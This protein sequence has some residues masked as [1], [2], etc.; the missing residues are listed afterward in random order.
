MP[1]ASVEVEAG[2]AALMGSNPAPEM[3]VIQGST[4]SP[5]GPEMGQPASTPDPERADAESPAAEPEMAKLRTFK[6]LAAKAGFAAEELWNLEL[7]LPKNLGTMKLSEFKDRLTELKEVDATREQ[8]ELQRAGVRQ[9]RLKWTQELK[10][11]SAAGLREF[12]EQERGQIGQLLQR[13]AEVEAE[14]IM[15]AVP[16]W[17]NQA[18]LRADFE[19]MADLLKPYGFSP[20]DV[21]QALEGDSRFTLFMKDQLDRSRRLKAAEAK[22]KAAPKKLQAPAGQTQPADQLQRIYN[23][24][25]RSAVDRGLAALMQGAKR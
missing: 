11:A 15:A 8:V 9:E 1:V 21:A 25:K 12:S 17:A 16:E 14:T 18:T 5:T 3:A 7:D 20:T 24:P 4:G 22:V 10:A 2:F 6:D 13:H 19:G 23:D